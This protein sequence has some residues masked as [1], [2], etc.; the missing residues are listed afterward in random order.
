MAA[1]TSNF[2]SWFRIQF[3]HQF[4]VGLVTRNSPHVAAHQSNI[5]KLMANSRSSCLPK[6]DD[7]HSNTKMDESFGSYSIGMLSGVR[8]AFR[9]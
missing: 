6:I 4:R 3:L 5:P 9:N 2:K 8:D 1:L 7:A